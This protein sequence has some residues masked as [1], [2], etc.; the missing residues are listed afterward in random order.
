MTLEAGAARTATTL[1]RIRADR[2][3]RW[4]ATA[5]GLAIGIVAATIDPLGIVLGGALVALPARTPIRGV[6]RGVCFGV[7]VLGGFAVRLWLAD[8]IG[9]AIDL[10]PPLWLAIGIGLG[11]GTLG[12]LVRGVV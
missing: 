2:Q 12:G 10:G 11:L 1:E 6:I 3:L 8:A 5:A 7:F 9:P 4:I